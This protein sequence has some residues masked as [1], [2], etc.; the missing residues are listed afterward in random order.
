M[1]MRVVFAALVLC[2]VSFAVGVVGDLSLAAPPGPSATVMIPPNAVRAHPLPPL[3]R[4]GEADAA[5]IRARVHAWAPR[6][7]PRAS[8][9]K[10]EPKYDADFA[11]KADQD[12]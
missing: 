6:A 4:T 10:A 9:A 12:K 1:L 5:P 7:K 11:P 8:A 3:P 2:L